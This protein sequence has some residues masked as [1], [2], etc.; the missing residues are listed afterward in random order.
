MPCRRLP[1]LA[2]F[3]TVLGAQTALAQQ[4]V[5]VGGQGTPGV[6]INLSAIYGGP[7]ESSVAP[8]PALQSDLASR[9]GDRRLQIP[10]L[11][12]TPPA[13]QIILRAP[14]P[15]SVRPMAPVAALVAPA[16]TPAARPIVAM[17]ARPVAK[18]PAV[19]LRTVTRATGERLAAPPAPP[20]APAAVKQDPAKF[21]RLAPPPPP[22]VVMA[23][24]PPP[25]PVM[26]PAATV[27]R[28]IAPRP[29]PAAPKAP[30]PTAALPKAPSLEPSTRRQ[31]TAKM[32]APPPPPPP[33]PP[34]IMRKADEATNTRNAAVAPR[35]EAPA[36]KNR[37]RLAALTPSGDSLLQLRFRDGSSVLTGDDEDRLKA[38]ADRV[39]STE[40][41]LQLKAYAAG[42]GNDTS[43]ARRLS[44]SRALAVRSFLIE[45]GL[46]STRIDV[47]AL[48]IP[49][50]GGAP[51]RVDI[52]LLGR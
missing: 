28:A 27:P 4:T 14:R 47:R 40:A 26:A 3:L 46:R 1:F 2:V 45:N 20:A 44:L 10:N 17:K 43:K 22:P 7:A 49:R 37:Q 31:S 36:T 24:T 50:D 29:M 42:N 30:M 25:P 6:T 21:A 16:A 38:M 13:R 8:I 41:R 34:T 9:L 33:P 19:P 18:M 12:L 15:A 51:D 5:F 35:S 39:A 23:K 52:V 11:N 48:G 32:A